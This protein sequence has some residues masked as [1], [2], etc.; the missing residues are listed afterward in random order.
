MEKGK[1]TVDRVA[2]GDPGPHALA[3]EQELP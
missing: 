1:T 2:R 3:E